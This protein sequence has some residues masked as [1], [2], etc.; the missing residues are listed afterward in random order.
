MEHE[1]EYEWLVED[2][3]PYEAML[4]FG[5]VIRDLEN[6]DDWRREIR[7]QARADN[8]RIRTF[9]VGTYGETTRV[10]AGFVREPSDKEIAISMR[11]LPKYCAAASSPMTSC[12]RR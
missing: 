9:I 4:R 10:W 12:S 3:D 8:R 6:P 5:N 1:A 2:P 11:F 7:R